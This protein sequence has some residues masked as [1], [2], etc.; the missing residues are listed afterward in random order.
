MY[1]AA[2]LLN[3]S[4]HIPRPIVLA[5]TAVPPIIDP[6]CAIEPAATPAALVTVGAAFAAPAL[7]RLLY[8]SRFAGSYKSIDNVLPAVSSV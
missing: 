8:V 6:I 4:F 7:T 5:S 2:Y 3:S 1:P